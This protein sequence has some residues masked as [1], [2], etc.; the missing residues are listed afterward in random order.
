MPLTELVYC[1][2]VAF[3]MTEW[4]DEK[5][6][7]PILKLSCRLFLAKH[8]ITQVCH[9]PYSLD[10][11]PCDFWFFPKL[12]S[13]FKGRGF[14]NATVTQYTGSVIGVSLLND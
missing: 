14:V 8:H 7:L 5:M 12:K 11:A 3:T 2:T 9:P 13:P 4:A 6:R 10:L 1:V